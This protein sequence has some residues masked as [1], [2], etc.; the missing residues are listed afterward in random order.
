ME[1]DFFSAQLM[2][3]MQGYFYE[4]KGI[5]LKLGKWTFL[6]RFFFQKAINVHTLKDL[7]DP[8][9]NFF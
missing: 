4:L 8:P 5:F 9:R 6:Y 3:P 2:Q 7:T 1:V